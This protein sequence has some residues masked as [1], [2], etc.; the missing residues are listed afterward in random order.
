MGNIANY[1]RESL[2]SLADYIIESVNSLMD[3]ISAGWIRLKSWLNDNAWEIA[4]VAG[5]V[6]IGGAVGVGAV[7]AVGAV[8]GAV[9]GAVVGAVGVGVVK[10]AY[11]AY[12]YFRDR[13][14]VVLAL[15]G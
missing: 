1:I 5:G 3:A 10:G 8:G 13:R 15:D 2:R 12:Q 6:V 14:Q 4:L 9:G 7:G 11:V